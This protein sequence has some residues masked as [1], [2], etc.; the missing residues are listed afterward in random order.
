MSPER[1][2]AVGGL[3]GHRDDRRNRPLRLRWPSDVMKTVPKRWLSRAIERS[4]QAAMVRRPAN[5][6]RSVQESKPERKAD[7]PQSFPSSLFRRGEA[8]QSVQNSIELLVELL[9]PSLED[10]GA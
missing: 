4:N 7:E 1:S 9:D 5:L 6:S 3:P 10:R 8:G 2:V